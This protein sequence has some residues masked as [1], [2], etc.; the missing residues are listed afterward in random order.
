MGCGASTAPG[1]EGTSANAQAEADQ[2]PAPVPKDATENSQ[3]EADKA[4][5]PTPAPAATPA[6]APTPAPA[7]SGTVSSETV[8]WESISGAATGLAA[9]THASFEGEYFYATLFDDGEGRRRVAQWM[10]GGDPVEDSQAGWNIK[11]ME[12]GTVV[13]THATLRK[14]SN[15]NYLYAA[16]I[17]DGDGRRHVYAWMDRGSAKDDPAAKWII[18]KLGDG[19]FVIISAEF[20]DNYLYAA[21]SDDGEG[22]RNIYCWMKGGAPEEDPQAKWKFVLLPTGWNPPAPST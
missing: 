4:P 9:L 8:S 5:A 19:S 18:K 15:G 12:D 6:P 21:K 11:D 14:G 7:S 1:Q 20:K 13:I 2:T 22:R 16:K 17:D 3:A 10:K